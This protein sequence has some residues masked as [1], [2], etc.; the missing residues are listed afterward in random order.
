[1][2]K[3]DAKQI[4][5]NI[6]NGKSKRDKRFYEA[7]QVYDITAAEF[8]RLAREARRREGRFPRRFILTPTSHGRR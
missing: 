7:P 3:S 1:M 4:L 8:D 2:T 5:T 6:W